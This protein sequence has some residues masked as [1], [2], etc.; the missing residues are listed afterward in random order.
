MSHIVPLST[1]PIGLNSKIEIMD[2]NSDIKSR[3]LD[4]GFIKGTKISCVLKNPSGELSAYLIRQTVIAL[5]R[6]DSDN[7]H[8]IV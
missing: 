1:L 6:E 2:V 5:R 3:L 7:I 4:L 8:V